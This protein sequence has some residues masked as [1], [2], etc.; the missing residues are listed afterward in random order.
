MRPTTLKSILKTAILAVA[1][2]VMTASASN[3]QQVWAE[4]ESSPRGV[5]SFFVHFCPVRHVC[6]MLGYFDR[7]RHSSGAPATGLLKR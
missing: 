3:A 4:R 1:G 7:L 6:G 2:L 5:Y